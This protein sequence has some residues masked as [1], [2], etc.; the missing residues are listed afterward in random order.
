MAS[1]RY[2]RAITR[3]DGKVLLT[4]SAFPVCMK[5]GF[6]LCAVLWLGA[7]NAPDPRFRGASATRITVQG[8]TFD[9]RVRDNRAEAI[10]VN[11]QYAPR[12]GP[13]QAR[14]GAAM[15]AVSG[16]RVVDVTGD[17]AQAFGRLDCG[18]GPPAKR[19]QAKRVDCEPLPGTELT[20]LGAI[21]V[22]LDCITV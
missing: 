10:R 18:N 14:A 20:E 11:M 6:L 3:S 15:A 17:Q 8:S 13:I 5:T 4:L 9:V 2:D 21:S 7:C 1:S 19:H 12:F 22:E 16:C